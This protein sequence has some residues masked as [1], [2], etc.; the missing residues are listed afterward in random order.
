MPIDDFR[1][2]AE[3][4]RIHR[5]PDDPLFYSKPAA[6][7][8]LRKTPDPTRLCYGLKDFKRAGEEPVKVEVLL[9]RDQLRRE[10]LPAKVSEVIAV[11]NI[12][13]GYCE[14]YFAGLISANRRRTERGFED[15][16]IHIIPVL[17]A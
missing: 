1:A 9:S 13:G 15:T 10:G 12:S 11:W 8:Y 2:V 6:E 14:G 3:L 5:T 16:R 4:Y 17:S 7:K